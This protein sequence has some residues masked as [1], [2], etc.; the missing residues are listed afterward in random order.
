[1]F[2][3]DERERIASEHVCTMRDDL[4]PQY[5]FSKLHSFILNIFKTFYE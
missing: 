2:N 5:N 4:E 3:Y 1:M